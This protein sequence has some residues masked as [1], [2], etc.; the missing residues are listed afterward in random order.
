MIDP[1]TRIRRQRLATQRLTA[2]RLSTASGAVRLLTCAQSQER[3]H[4]FFS[5]AL[6]SRARTYAAV[7]AEHDDGRFLRTHILRPTWHFVAPEDLRWIQRLT[8]PRV[9]QQM[10]GTNRR[11]GVADP[12]V[13]GAFLDALTELLAD[14]NTL[15]R[16]EIT[17]ALAQ[18]NSFPT[19]GMAWAHLLMLAEL[20]SV[21]CSGPMRGVHHS[22]G[23]VEELVPAVSEELTREAALARL[24]HR[25]F[26]GHG[27]ASIRDLARWATLTLGDCRAAVA[28]I[29]ADR[30]GTLES[31]DVDGEPHYWDPSVTARTTRRVGAFLF[32]TYDEIVLSYPQVRFTT[33]P[34]HPYAASDDPFWAQVVC[35][36]VNVGLWKRAVSGSTVRVETRLAPT[37]DRASRREVARAAQGLADFLEL[38]LDYVEGEGTPHLWG[39]EQGHPARRPRRAGRTAR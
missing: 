11:L 6:R 31:V 38:E 1:A 32:P 15:S 12:A 22:Y 21:I 3:D 14:H 37:V 27:P 17:T 7:Q 9:E 13:Q 26:A 35:G 19:T 29:E 30:P 4:A 5:L 28:V 18:H 2:G 24:A 23:L 20:R 34:D 8:G 36:Q 33:I 39:G 16:N 10:A 25:F